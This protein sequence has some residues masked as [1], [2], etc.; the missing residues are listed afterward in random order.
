MVF[1]DDYLCYSYS[2]LLPPSLGLSK[3]YLNVGVEDVVVNSL[4]NTV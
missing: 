1:S 2:V 4:E 3:T